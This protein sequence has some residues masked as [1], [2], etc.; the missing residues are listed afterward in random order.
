MSELLFRI[1][2]PEELDL[3]APP[4][5]SIKQEPLKRRK[6]GDTIGV[7]VA[8]G[9]S[10]PDQVRVA[11]G[12]SEEM[13]ATELDTLREGLRGEVLL[14]EVARARELD[15]GGVAEIASAVGIAEVEVHVIEL[16]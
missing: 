3:P 8:A 14:I 4:G 12:Y 9:V 1:E 7:G 2:A 15:L 11:I 10:L 13:T 16:G 5:V 6:E